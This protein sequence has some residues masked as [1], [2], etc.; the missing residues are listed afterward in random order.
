M[1]FLSIGL[2]SLGL[3][4]VLLSTVYIFNV[5]SSNQAIDV[6]DNSE[7]SNSSE[8][9]SNQNIDEIFEGWNEVSILDKNIIVPYDFSVAPEDAVSDTQ[10]FLFVNEDRSVRLHGYLTSTPIIVIDEENKVYCEY[11]KKSTNNYS[12]SREAKGACG[13]VEREEFRGVVYFNFDYSSSKAHKTYAVA[14]IDDYHFVFESILDVEELRSIGDDI[15]KLK[16][17]HVISTLNLAETF[18]QY[19]TI[20]N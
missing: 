16:Q 9:E 2:I 14:Q 1:H 12:S 3:I 15:D 13:H 10:D 17:N 18:A 20:N 5:Q 7:N 4:V 6:N 11:V 19:Y 8:S